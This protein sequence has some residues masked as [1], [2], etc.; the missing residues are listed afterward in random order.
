MRDLEDIEAELAMTTPAPWTVDRFID[1]P[2]YAHM[3]PEWKAARRAEEA[4]TVR[5]SHGGMILTSVPG[6][7]AAVANTRFAANAR[8]D[9]PEM[10]A[11]IRRLRSALAGHLF[12]GES[13]TVREEVRGSMMDI[14]VRHMDALAEV[15]DALRNLDAIEV[16]HPSAVGEPNCSAAGVASVIRKAIAKALNADKEHNRG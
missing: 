16:M 14:A 7:P 11:E 5:T 13:V 10:A 1:S 12:D 3:T 2:R 9:V 4:R 15:E 6:V 8:Q